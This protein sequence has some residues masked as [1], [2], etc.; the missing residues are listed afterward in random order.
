MNA[1]TERIDIQ[2]VVASTAIDQELDLE[3]LV[4]DIPGAEFNPDN[5]PGLV[6]RTQDP[7]AAALIFRSGKI[8]CTGAASVDDVHTALGIIFDKLRGL[9]IPVAESPEITV[10]N[11][12]SSADLGHDLNLNALAIGLGLEDVEYEPEQFP[13]LVYRMDDPKVVVLL[14]GSGKIVITGGKFAEDATAAV[15]NIVDR[16]DGLGLLG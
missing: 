13:G 7:K 16:L 15:E 9:G 14:F 11:I 12:V 1:P 4:D 10:Q 5:F 6:D 3:T 2:N 8:V